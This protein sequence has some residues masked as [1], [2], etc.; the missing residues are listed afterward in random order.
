MREIIFDTETTGLKPEDGERIIEIGAVEFVNRM[1]S[2]RTFHKYVNPDG[3]KVD[4]GAF[5]VHGIS[6]GQLA[7]EPTFAEIAGEFLEFIEGANL[8]AHNAPFDIKFL[9]YELARLDHPP[10]APDRVVDTLDIARRK[11]PMAQNSLDRLCER[12]GIDNRHR[13]LHGALLDAQL[14]A[15]VYIELLGGRQVSLEL[16]VESEDQ[17]ED[18]GPAEDLTLAD[19]KRPAPLAPRLTEKDRSAHR[20]FVETLGEDAIWNRYS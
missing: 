15:E 12:Y 3:R 18:T 11:H 8:V 2:G 10:I 5:A 14:L 16:T 19:L 17:S 7:G 1:P 4:P 9:N 6:D 20:K 13:T